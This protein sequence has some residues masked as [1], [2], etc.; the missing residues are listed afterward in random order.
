V[1]ELSGGEQQRVALARAL[2]PRPRLLMLDEPLAS[3]D[4]ALREHLM[5]ELR[6][7]LH[8]TGIPAIY[9]T[10]DQQ[11]AYAIADRILLLHD[12][13]ILREGTPAEVWADPR[14]AWVAR[15]L[16]VGNVVEGVVVKVSKEPGGVCR[17]ETEVGLLKMECAH[18]HRVGDR[19]SL[20]LRESS[21]GTQVKAEVE[22]V[23]FN[24]DRF[25]VT[26]RGGLTIDLP[27]APVVDSRISVVFGVECLGHA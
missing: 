17:V 26:L 4:R 10:H 11:E 15:F 27:A 12:G 25:R 8:H 2:A 16:G 14:S 20:L 22:D 19:V 9:V 3:L 21:A 6:N 1:A 5:D 24:R 7:I 23:V 13:V 18:G